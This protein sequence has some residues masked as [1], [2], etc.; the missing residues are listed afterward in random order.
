MENNNIPEFKD[1]KNVNIE[2]VNKN[3]AETEDKI[4][5]VKKTN[6]ASI[7]VTGFF[8][9]ILIIFFIYVLYTN[10]KSKKTEQVVQTTQ[11]QATAVSPELQL[12]NCLKVVKTDSSETALFD[13][14]LAYINNKMYIEGIRIY[15][16]VLKTNPNH[17]IANN[18]IGYAYGCINDFDNAIKYCRISVKLDPNFQLAKNNLNW[19]L[20]EKAKA[21]KK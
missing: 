15:K 13:L 2:D 4:E 1:E 5:N 8:I 7:I 21:G 11:Q 17:V 18:N 14:G 9:L 19:F 3:K 10:F 12:V 6:Y 20:D 16:K